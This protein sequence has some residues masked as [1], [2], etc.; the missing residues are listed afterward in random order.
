MPDI[1]L[2]KRPDIRAEESKRDLGQVAPGNCS[3]RLVVDS[4]LKKIYVQYVQEIVTQPKILN[5]T[6][7]SNWIHVT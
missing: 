3:R 1:R 6:I 7:L 4:N 5:R 2:W